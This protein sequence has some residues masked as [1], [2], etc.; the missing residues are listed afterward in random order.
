MTTIERGQA[1]TSKSG[2]A[3]Q[4]TCGT[5]TPTSTATTANP[6]STFQFRHICMQSQ[7]A[8]RGEGDGEV[9][10]VSL[11][12]TS[13]GLPSCC[14]VALEGVCSLPMRISSHI[15]RPMPTGQA[16]MG[17][18]ERIFCISSI[19]FSIRM[20]PGPPRTRSRSCCSCWT[21]GGNQS[22]ITVD[23][24]SQSHRCYRVLRV[25]GSGV[26]VHIS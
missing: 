22:A 2:M 16:R 13:R 18:S 7:I 23:Q 5:T 1:S 15:I 26:P 4:K 25:R 10:G 19:P 14:T 17:S 12:A 8:L 20:L 21:D 6:I 9:C 11:E 24:G 3:R